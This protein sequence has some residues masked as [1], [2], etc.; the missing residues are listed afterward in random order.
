MTSAAAPVHVAADRGKLLLRIPGMGDR[1][2]FELFEADLSEA[3]QR[4][5]EQVQ[6]SSSQVE[7]IFVKDLLK[8][9]M[10]EKFAGDGPMADFI[11]DQFLDALAQQSGR[12]GALGLSKMLREKLSES[13]YRQEAARHLGERTPE[14]P[15]QP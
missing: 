10:P 4:E 2:S 14:T 6:K 9:M 1:P 3:A 15:T 5:L 13:I 12:S 8:K 11:R 7:A